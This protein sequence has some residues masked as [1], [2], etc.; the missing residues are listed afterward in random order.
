MV[1]TDIVKRD[2]VEEVVGHRNAAIAAFAAQ[3]TAWDACKVAF[4]R[5][6]GEYNYG[7]SRDFGPKTTDLAAFI[8]HVDANVWRR[9]FSMTKIC[10]LMDVTARET[11]QKQCSDAPPEVTVDNVLATLNGLMASAADIFKRC[12]VSTFEALPSGYRSNDGFKY[13]KRIIFTDALNTTFSMWR[14]NHYSH[15]EARLKDL[16][17]AF[18]IID[19]KEPKCTLTNIEQA[20]SAAIRTNRQFDITTTYFRIKGFAAGTLHVW[21]VRQDLTDKANLILA[22]HYGWVLPD[23]NKGHRKAA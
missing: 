10:D 17:K 22:E 21:P 18:H 15:A 4:D 11:F 19:G 16:D 23:T 14:F 5:A 3:V 20:I 7:P 12:I 8:K 2:T 6:K 9:L 1:G 13:G